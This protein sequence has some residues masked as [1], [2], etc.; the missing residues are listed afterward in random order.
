MPPLDWLPLAQA[1][2]GRLL[3]QRLEMPIARG[4][5]ILPE[6]SRKHTRS[7]EAIVKSLGEGA[8]EMVGNPLVVGDQVLISGLSGRPIKF[9][10]REEVELLDIPAQAVLAILPVELKDEAV[11]VE[12]HPMQHWDRTLE[13]AQ[14]GLEEGDRRAL[15]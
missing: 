8:E 7:A 4:R 13:V 1:L 3:V 12:A 10:L 14:D 5:I 11:T 6:S 9:G 2:P 15:R